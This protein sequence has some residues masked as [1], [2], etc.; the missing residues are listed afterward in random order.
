MHAYLRVPTLMERMRFIGGRGEGFFCFTG[1]GEV[2]HV[3]QCQELLEINDCKQ[4][5]L[6]LVLIPTPLHP[7]QFVLRPLKY[8]T[9]P[10]GIIPRSTKFIPPNRSK[11]CGPYICA[12][13]F[14]YASIPDHSDVMPRKFACPRKSLSAWRTATL[15]SA[16]VSVGLRRRS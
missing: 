13:H 1:Q 10:T 5:L 9:I 6:G 11:I 3:F 7:C 12:T 2:V 15:G 14:Q 8:P 4:V 16:G